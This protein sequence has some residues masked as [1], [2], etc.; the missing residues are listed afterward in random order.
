MILFSN[1]ILG[2]KDGLPDEWDKTAEMLRKTAKTV[3]R[4]TFGKH[5]GNWNIG[6]PIFT[7]IFFFRSHCCLEFL[8]I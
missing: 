1:I 8:H 4:V 5:L 2:G 3:L 6:T 7:P